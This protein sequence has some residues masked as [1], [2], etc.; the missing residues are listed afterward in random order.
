LNKSI[1]KDT[2]NRSHWI[3]ACVHVSSSSTINDRILCKIK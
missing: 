2:S 3:T 1:H